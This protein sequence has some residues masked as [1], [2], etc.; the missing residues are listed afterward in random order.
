MI[1]GQLCLQADRATRILSQVLKRIE[2]HKE[3]TAVAY[4]PDGKLA[5]SGNVNGIVRVWGFPG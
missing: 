1:V 3:V 2:N 4:S 5:A